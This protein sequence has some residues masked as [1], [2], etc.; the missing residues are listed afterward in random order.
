MAGIRKSG[1]GE[2]PEK[3]EVEDAPG[4]G[5]RERLRGLYEGMLRRLE[6]M[7]GDPR[8]LARTGGKP[9]EQGGPEYDVVRAGVFVRALMDAEK[10]RRELYDLPPAREVWAARKKARGEEGEDNRVFLPP[11]LPEEPPDCPETDR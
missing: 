3:N 5:A 10:L 8:L 9:G 1:C 6:E 11:V 2:E 7:N 4:E